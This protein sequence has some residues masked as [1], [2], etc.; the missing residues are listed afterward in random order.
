[1]TKY[2]KQDAIRWI[3]QKLLISKKYFDEE[4]YE[5]SAKTYLSIAKVIKDWKKLVIQDK[6]QIK[7]NDFPKSINKKDIIK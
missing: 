1:M 3:E 5:E 2:K 7:N 4:N 6:P